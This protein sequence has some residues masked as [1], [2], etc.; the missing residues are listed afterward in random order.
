[1]LKAN[2]DWGAKLFSLYVVAEQH[3]LV[4]DIQFA[5]GEDRVCP[6]RLFRAV[7]LLETAALKIFFT[8]RF[9]EE[10]R[11]GLGAV[12]NPAVAEDDRT[13]AHPAF[14]GITFVP[15]N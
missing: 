14:I 5:V 10:H 8:I 15:E 6:G 3:L 7:G 13:F 12:V 9:N 4:A 1:M 2:R 11:A